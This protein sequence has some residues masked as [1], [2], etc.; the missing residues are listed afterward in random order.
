M[1]VLRVYFDDSGEESDPQHKVCSIGGFVTTARKWKKL[2]R[3]WRETLNSPDFDVPYFHMKEFAHCIGPFEKWKNK[4][5]KR[6]AFLQSLIEIIRE[7]NLI[8][9][10]SI[11]IL[12]DF[13]RIKAEKGLDI[14]DYSFNLY[15]CIALMYDKVTKY[16]VE[17]FVDR[18]N[19]VH[20]KIDK[21]LKYFNTDGRYPGNYVQ[22]TPLA[23]WLTFKEVI[24]I[25]VADFIAWEARDDLDTKFLWFSNPNKGNSHYE[26]AKSLLKW[27]EKE[28]KNS[29]SQRV[30]DSSFKSG[31]H[32]W[33]RLGLSLYLS[34][35]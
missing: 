33:D 21:A 15:N 26:W 10:A 13:R 27:C 9:I 30:V 5:N 12:E 34:T 4:E 11:L 3:K 23:K 31:P 35:Q 1:A 14:N 19:D 6:I 8:G 24:P 18:T 22:I 17:V 16:H 25:Q 28:N 2:E 7:F 20:L 32:L 29:L